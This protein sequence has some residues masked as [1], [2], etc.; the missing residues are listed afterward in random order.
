MKKVLVLVLLFVPLLMGANCSAKKDAAV[1][2]AVNY[3][4]SLSPEVRALERVRVDAILKPRTIRIDC[5]DGVSNLEI[6]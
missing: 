3:Y 6:P 1:Q 4:C 2:N 5:A